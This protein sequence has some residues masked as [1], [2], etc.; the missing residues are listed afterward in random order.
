MI[1]TSLGNP[2]VPNHGTMKKCELGVHHE[3][4]P[5]CL[6]RPWLV[7]KVITRSWHLHGAPQTCWLMWHKGSHRSRQMGCLRRNS[8]TSEV[9][10]NLIVTS[11]GEL[12][13]MLVLI[14]HL[15]V[16]GTSHS[17]KTWQTSLSSPGEL[18]P[19]PWNPRRWQGTD[20]PSPSH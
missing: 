13:Q 4:L 3:W 5:P 11:Q 19:S 14:G 18:W 20:L 8:G 10:D 9:Q 16:T 6:F 1:R 17:W 7:S 15:K 12:G 2:S